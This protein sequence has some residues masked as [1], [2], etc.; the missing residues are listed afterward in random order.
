M[1]NKDVVEAILKY[2]PTFPAEYAG[3]DDYKCGNPEDECKGIV[4]ALVPT[5]NVI[6]K[7]IE[8]GA[9]LIITHEPTFYTSKDE[10]GW[11]EDFSNSTFEEKSQLLKEYGITIWRDHDHMHAHRPD[12]IFNGVVKHLE[13]DK[14]FYVND[15]TGSFAHYVCSIEPTTLLD[16]CKHVSEKMGINGCKY[17]GNPNQIV[18]KVALIGHLYPMGEGSEYSVNVI[19]ELEHQGVDVIMPGETIDWTVASYIRDSIQLGKSKGMI[20]V[21]HFNIEELGMKEFKEHLDEILNKEVKVTYVHSEDMYD[22][23]SK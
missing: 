23:Y 14:D 9:N 15:K 12:E 17:L 10:A 7:A 19:K 8:L 20:C 5:I 11:F 3:C 1:K 22:Y 4:V 6:K 18:S 13:W 16:V 21:G 2:H